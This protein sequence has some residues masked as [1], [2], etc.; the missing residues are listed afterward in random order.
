MRARAH[1][2]EIQFD[3]QLA[4]RVE[5]DATIT[6]QRLRC[7]VDGR[8]FGLDLGCARGRGLLLG[9]DV[10]ADALPLVACQGP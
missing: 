6:L 8:V 7:V 9:F 3:P 10:I 4:V 5:H 1:L 2:T